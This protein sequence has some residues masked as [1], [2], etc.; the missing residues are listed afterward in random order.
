MRRPTD[1]PP[2]LPGPI[3]ALRVNGESHDEPRLSAAACML[4]GV[5]WAPLSK[6]A[7]RKKRPSQNRRTDEVPGGCAPLVICRHSCAAGLSGGRRTGSTSVLGN[8]PK[9][10]TPPNWSGPALGCSNTEL[11]K[12]LHVY[13]GR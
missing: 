5:G 6:T 3:V 10:S 1:A 4:S 13:F 9:A 7:L 11:S 2:C 8:Q 12:P